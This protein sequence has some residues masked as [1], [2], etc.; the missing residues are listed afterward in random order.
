MQEILRISPPGREEV[1]GILWVRIAIA[2]EDQDR[3][4]EAVVTKLTS[5]C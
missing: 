3:I 2:L 1:L 5:L 4:T